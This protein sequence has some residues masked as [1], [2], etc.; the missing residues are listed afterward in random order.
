MFRSR[1]SLFHSPEDVAQITRHSLNLIDARTPLECEK[2]KLH[3]PC[4][5]FY[6]ASSASTAR[7]L[8]S[9]QTVKQ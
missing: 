5:D 9:D 7:R 2:L 3:Q 6:R 4:P 8:T 1:I